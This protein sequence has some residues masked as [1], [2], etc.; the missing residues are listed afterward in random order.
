[1]ALPVFFLAL[2]LFSYLWSGRKALIL[3]LFLL[4]LINSTPDIFFNGYPFNYMGIPLFYLSGIMMRFALKKRKAGVCFSRIRDLY[5]LFLA[6]DRHFRFLC[7]F[8]LVQPDPLRA[9]LPA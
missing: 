3:F 9:G 2:G 6:S 5:L 1:M 4:P 7:V 8:A